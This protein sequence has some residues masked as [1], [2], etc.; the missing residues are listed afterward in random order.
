MTTRVRVL[1]SDLALFPYGGLAHLVLFRLYVHFIYQPPADRSFVDHPVT[2]CAI[3]L[4]GGMF[5]SVLTLLVL[6]RPRARASLGGLPLVAT[7]T[8]LEVAGTALTIQGFLILTS[9]FLAM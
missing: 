4:L 5:V 6:G 9:V 7:T 2:N 8:G 1:F 3:G